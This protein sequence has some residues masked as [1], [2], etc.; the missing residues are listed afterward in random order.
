MF[1]C[2]VARKA[3]EF[4][5][6]FSTMPVVESI[7]ELKQLPLFALLAYA[8]RC[9]RRV[10]PLFRVDSGNPEAALCQQAVESAIRLSEDLASGK[11][12]DPVELSAAE[13]GT[14]HAV[15]IASEAMPPD[16][17]AAY[18]ANSAYAAIS[19]AKAL[20]EAFASDDRTTEADRV[21]EAAAIARDAAVSA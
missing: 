18:A 9:A 6:R 10:F 1:V 4:P 7:N 19:A 11:E 15:V 12:I 5:A 17:Q 20:L 21:A 13:E 3:A 2:R 16:E 14:I 8:A